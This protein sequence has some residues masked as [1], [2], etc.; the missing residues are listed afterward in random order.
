MLR[1]LIAAALAVSL[2]AFASDEVGGPAPTYAAEGVVMKVTARSSDDGVDWAEVTLKIPRCIAGAC[3]ANT[4]V[5]VQIAYS[6]WRG[7]HGETMG[8]T[9]YEWKDKAGS[10]RAWMAAHR[11]DDAGEHER[12]DWDCEKAMETVGA[13]PAVSDSAVATR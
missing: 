8:I 7:K 11:L 5:K 13:S 10:G 1:S 4:S 2:P 12:F 6:Q 9:R 3:S